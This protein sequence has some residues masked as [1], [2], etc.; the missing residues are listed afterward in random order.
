MAGGVGVMI[1][2]VVKA[3]TA[4][5]GRL[6]VLDG[7]SLS[8]RPGEFVSVLG[9]SGAGKTTLLRLI[10][11]LDRPQG[12]EVAIVDGSRRRLDR[13]AIRLGMVFQEPRLLPW[14]SLFHNVRYGLQ[15]RAKSMSPAERER[16]VQEALELLGLSGF[17]SYL[18]H[19]VSGGMAQRAALARALVSDPDLLLLDEPLGS[20]DVKN[21]LAVQDL[22]DG[23]AGRRSCI[24]VT[25]SI[26]EA[27]YLVG[28]YLH[29]ERK[30][31]VGGGGDRGVSPRPRYR[32]SAG[33]ARCQRR[34]LE[35]LG[36]CAPPP[37]SRAGSQSGR[38]N[39]KWCVPEGERSPSLRSSSRLLA[40]SG[41]ACAQ[42]GPVRLRVSYNPVPFNAASPSSCARASSRSG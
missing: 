19:Q 4:G 33:F 15:D 11:G 35:A 28:L 18:P 23:M 21:R 29:P 20:L 31:R 38:V 36:A 34:V 16:A 26:D 27:V 8:C 24:M 39:P 25:Q 2:D 32:L 7:V 10:A 17:S 22:L 13:T 6:L 40:G 42:S 41:M 9:P 37:A 12:G 30:A 5:A 3:F 14:A 1:R